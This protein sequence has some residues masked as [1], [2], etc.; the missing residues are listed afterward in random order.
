MPR[1]RRPRKRLRQRPEREVADML[2]TASKGLIRAAAAGVR[3]CGA[4]RVR[5][6]RDQHAG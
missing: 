2:T 3:R 5:P 4:V 6:W 1:K